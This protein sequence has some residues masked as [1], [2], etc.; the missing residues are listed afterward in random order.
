MDYVHVGVVGDRVPARKLGEFLA[1]KK[2]CHLTNAEA[3]R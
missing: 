1:V 3:G 2:V